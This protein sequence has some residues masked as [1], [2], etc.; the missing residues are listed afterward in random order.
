MASSEPEGRNAA[1]N[2]EDRATD[3]QEHSIPLYSLEGRPADAA[4][5]LYNLDVDGDDTYVANG[6]VVHNKL[7]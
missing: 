6:L 1:R 4:T 5:Q 2:T 3:V 7:F